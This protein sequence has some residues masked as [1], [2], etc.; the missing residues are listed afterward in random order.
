MQYR[1]RF[2]RNPLV[3][4]PLSESNV[5]V[6]LFTMSFELRA[7]C[8]LDALGE[9]PC[10]YFHSALSFLSSCD[11]SI[12]STDL[13]FGTNRDVRFERDVCLMRYGN[14][15]ASTFTV[16]FRFSLHVMFLYLVLTS[17][18]DRIAMCALREML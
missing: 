9:F 11:V 5:L 18:S 7:R 12:F 13:P 14:F 10:V 4:K 17:L 6:G 8:V 2:E 15:H 3:N 16:L 1:V